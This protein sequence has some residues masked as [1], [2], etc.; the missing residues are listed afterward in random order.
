MSRV[1]YRHSV[2]NEGLMETSRGNGKEDVCFVLALSLS[3]SLLHTPHTRISSFVSLHPT[4]SFSLLFLP[5]LS[6]SFSRLSGKL[7]G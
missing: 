4:S 6:P 5:L 7:A 1:E 3:L 2:N